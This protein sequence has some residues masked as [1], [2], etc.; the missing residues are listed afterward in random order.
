MLISRDAELQAAGRFSTIPEPS[1]PRWDPEVGRV[2][3][4]LLRG[5]QQF[6]VPKEVLQR[7]CVDVCFFC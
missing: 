5:I 6:T 2:L 1:Y 7:L 3:L 4:S